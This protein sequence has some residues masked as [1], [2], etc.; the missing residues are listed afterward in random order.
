MAIARNNAGIKGILITCFVL[1]AVALILI[2]NSPITGYEASIYTGTPIQVWLILF[3]CLTC[4]IGIMIHQVYT[5][6]YEKSSL[7][8][9]GLLACS[10]SYFIVLLLPAL[11]GYFIYGRFDIVTHL[12][13]VVKLSS[14]HHIESQ[15]AYP[16]THI[17]IKEISDIC[18]ISP[19]TLF[20]YV[21]ALFSMLFII[22]V[23][24]IARL[25]LPTKGHA[26]SVIIATIA[27]FPALSPY[28]APQ[29]LSNMTLPLGLFIAIRYL[30]EDSR[31]SKGYSI[32]LVIMILLFPTF[33]PITALG[34]LI[35]VLTLALPAK[36]YGIVSRNNAARI[37][38]IVYE[39]ANS[40]MLLLAVWWLFWMMRFRS[41]D[42]AVQSIYFTLSEGGSSAASFLAEDID[43]ATEYGFSVTE[44]FF[45]GYGSALLYMVLTFV[46]CCLL[47]RKLR[48]DNNLKNLF[49]LFGPLVILTSLYILLF[50]FNMT[51]SPG[52]VFSYVMLL[53]V[54]FVGFLIYEILQ[55]KHFAK[56]EKLIKLCFVAFVI[57]LILVSVNRVLMVYPSRYS[58]AANDQVTIT[59]LEGMEWFLSNKDPNVN[60]LTRITLVSDRLEELYLA[61]QG[62]ESLH[63]GGTYS[64]QDAP[65]H[66]NYTNH[67]MLGESYEKDSY[68]MLNRQDRVRYTEIFPEV[69]KDR[70]Y[71][72]D[73]ERLERDVSINKL[74]SNA[75]LD[76]WFIHS[77]TK[78]S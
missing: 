55:G 36:A 54:I 53:C 70:F 46:S 42:F 24:L 39:R 61:Q 72:S 12:S 1:Q 22:Y 64:L 6:N 2:K 33:H 34:L 17:L 68:M 18:N 62:R 28:L 25:V 30:L 37:S 19:S 31:V 63:E 27:I 29:Q 69:A 20:G 56:G 3:F 8:I 50:G 40:A 49:S 41:F 10:F 32:L 5:K 52:R 26:I 59:E 45:K 77:S 11:R 14:N 9:A 51:L 78:S 15:N 35:M 74:Y 73:F 43:L 21:P 60:R 67:R 65:Y 38:N 47:I 7:W 4:G 48:S 13:T 44:Q 16:I 75:G 57:I 23:Y 66:F 58:L 76:V 71:P